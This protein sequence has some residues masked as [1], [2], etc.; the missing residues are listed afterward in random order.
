MKKERMLHSLY[1]VAC[2][3]LFSHKAHALIDLSVN[4]SYNRSVFREEETELNPTP[5]NAISTTQGWSVVLAWYLWEYT[6][7]EVNYSESTYR[8]E[9]RRDAISSDGITI[10]SVDSIVLSRSTGAGIRQAFASRKSW[11]IPMISIGFAKLTTSG[12]TT[13]NIEYTDATTGQVTEDEITIEEDTQVQNSG[14]ATFPLRFRF[15]R[16]MGV[17]LAVKTIVPEFEWDRAEDNMTYQAG[18]SWVF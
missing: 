13:Y 14:Y 10:R 7:L 12:S 18:L 5:E 4:Y 2:F 6:A 15:S 8:L 9:D 16:S 1:V 3:L 17:T 11:I